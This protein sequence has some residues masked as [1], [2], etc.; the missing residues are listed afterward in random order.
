MALANR[1]HG[2][3]ESCVAP[4]VPALPDELVDDPCNVLTGH[5]PDAEPPA[6][7]VG[8]LGKPRRNSGTF[9]KSPNDRRAAVAL[10]TRPLHVYA[11]AEAVE[12]PDRELVGAGWTDGGGHETKFGSGCRTLNRG[13]A[14]WHAALCAPDSIALGIVSPLLLLREAEVPRFG[15]GS[16]V[17]LNL[18]DALEFISD[19]AWPVA[20]LVVALAYRPLLVT[21]LEGKPAVVTGIL[22][23]DSGV[24]ARQLLNLRSPCRLA[25][26]GPG[27]IP[28][29][30]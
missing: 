6:A 3:S 20:V 25:N 11:E 1:F 10:A 7:A 28:S 17:G 24:M 13:Y 14:G 2:S 27:G 12:R 29:G 18:V 19:V 8:M 30:A 23:L 4:W 26:A 22:D 5:R 21:L 15:A 9:E 16:P